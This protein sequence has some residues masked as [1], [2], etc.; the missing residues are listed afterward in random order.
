MSGIP[1]RI[2]EL[3]AIDPHFAADLVRGAV[4][5]PR[6]HLHWD[7]SVPARSEPAE[8]TAGAVVS[9]WTLG[10]APRR[11]GHLHLVR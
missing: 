11:R 2:I 3:A 9:R 7:Y 6:T 1:P 4:R 8:A 5:V 10:A